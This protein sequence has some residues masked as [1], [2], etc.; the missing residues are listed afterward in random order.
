MCA[1]SPHTDHA[2]GHR[3]PDGR[4]HDHAADR[5]A[6]RN[7]SGN[8]SA[9]YSSSHC[10]RIACRLRA[11]DHAEPDVGLAVA[12]GKHPRIAAGSDMVAEMQIDRVGVD[13]D[14]RPSGTAR[15]SPCR[16]T[17]RAC[18]VPPSAR[19]CHSTPSAAITSRARTTSRRARLAAPRASRRHRASRPVASVPIRISAP[20]RPPPLPAPAR[21]ACG[22]ARSPRRPRP[23]APRCRPAPRK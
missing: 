7:P 15:S 4:M 8:S 16:A 2:I 23:R 22:R 1:A 20:A 19:P 21:S 17:A 12:L 6:T 3:A 18:R 10:A 9:T 14:A 5:V 11:G 13:V